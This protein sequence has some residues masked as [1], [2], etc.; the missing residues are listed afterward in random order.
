MRSLPEQ[1]CEHARMCGAPPSDTGPCSCRPLAIHELLGLSVGSGRRS[2]GNRGHFGEPSRTRI[3]PTHAGPRSWATAAPMNA[4]DHNASPRR[5]ALRRGRSAP[6]SDPRRL[7]A[8]VHQCDCDHRHGEATDDPRL[9]RLS[10]CALR[11]AVPPPGTPISRRGCRAPRAVPIGLDHDSW[12]I[13]HGTW[14][15]LV[16]AF[17][18]AESRWSS[19]DRRQK[20][21]ASTSSSAR[22]CAAP[23]R[24]RARHR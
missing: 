4:L 20:P 7:G 2:V 13:D 6:S 17:P 10:R 24:G 1:D 8:L 11:R 12:D 14:S 15:V 23:R 16:H 5:G 21:L 18:D 9:L 19:C 22:G 3:Q